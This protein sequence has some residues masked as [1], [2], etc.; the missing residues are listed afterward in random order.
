MT[1]KSSA[2]NKTILSSRNP[3]KSN[4]ERKEMGHGRLN[5]LFQS[6]TPCVKDYEIRS[7]VRKYPLG[8][9]EDI[10]EKTSRADNILEKLSET[11]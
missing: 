1:N 7:L 9:K 11:E 2:R 10:E 5:K 6:K 4:V 8:E 3:L